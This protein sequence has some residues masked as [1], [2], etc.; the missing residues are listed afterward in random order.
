[1][2]INWEVVEIAAGS[3]WMA[4]FGLNALNIP[5]RKERVCLWSVTAYECLRTFMENKQ[6]FSSVVRSDVEK[7]NMKKAMNV[8]FI[9]FM[10]L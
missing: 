1:M 10:A 7:L 8:V 6:H 4:D 5:F 9:I 3:C 2:E